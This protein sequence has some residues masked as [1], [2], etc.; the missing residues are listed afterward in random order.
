MISDT[1]IL[2]IV[3]GVVTISTALITAIFAKVNRTNAKLDKY[4]TAV[5]GKMDKLLDTT[6]ELGKAQGKAEEKLDHIDEGVNGKH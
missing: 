4:H 3:G 2:S 6:Q 5:N 1:V